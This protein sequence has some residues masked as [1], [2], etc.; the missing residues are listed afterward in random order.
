MGQIDDLNGSSLPDILRRLRALE[1]A[2]NQHNMSITRGNLRLA[3]GGSI[4]VE[5]GGLDVT[6]TA[7][8][9]GTLVASGDIDMSGSF[10]ASGD[11]N[12]NGPTEITGVTS[13]AG[14]TTVTGDFTVAGPTHLNG[15]TDIAGD[16]TVTGD[17]DV[18]GP[19]K[20]TGTLDVQGATT[21]RS[22]LTVTTGGRIKAGD[23]EIHPGGNI[24]FGPDLQITPDNGTGSAAIQNGA[25]EIVLTPENADYWAQ[26]TGGAYFQGKVRAAALRL[27]SL[28]TTSAP[29]NLFIDTDGTVKR[30]LA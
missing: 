5:N 9:S 28:P 4:I 18:N 2:S 23:T 24:Q 8:I 15:T 1:F 27:A 7:T 19:M 12:L 26:F 22:D 13:I 30:S 20:T 21:L 29:A 6:G 11:V 25:S 16:T 10:T 3:G 17:F 14:D